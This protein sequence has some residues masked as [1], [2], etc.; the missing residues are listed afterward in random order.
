M[1]GAII[2]GI[3]SL[4]C[5]FFAFRQF[6]EKGFL[7][8]NAYLYATKEERQNMNKKPYYRQSGIIFTLIGAIFAVN[9]VEMIRRT[10]WL[11][12]L[13]MTIAAITLIYAIVSSVRIER[14]RK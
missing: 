13:V 1:I 8:N 9:A 4:V 5:L 12:Y 14:N 6:N 11:F 2:S 10:G 7:L 3:V